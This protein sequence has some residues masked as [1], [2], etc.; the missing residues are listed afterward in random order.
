MTEISRVAWANN[1]VWIDAPACKKGTTQKAGT[2]GFKGV[3]EVVWNLYIG[4]YQV[5]EKWLK[6]RVGRTLSK[7]DIDHYRK[8]LVAL[9]ETIRLRDEIDNVINQHGGWPG[10]FIT[11]V[12][13]NSPGD[14]RGQL[15]F[16]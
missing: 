12:P 6:D 9:T 10:A 4:G 13:A 15:P 16:A 2:A 5:C 11:E 3:P 7:D 1:A 8:I 14:G